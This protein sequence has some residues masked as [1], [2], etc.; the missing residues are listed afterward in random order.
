VEYLFHLFYFYS[1]FFD[2]VIL[3]PHKTFF[4]F[5]FP[6][7]LAMILFIA[8][9]IV[10]IFIQSLFIEHEK[11]LIQIE[12][13]DPFGCETE[14]GVDIE[15]YTALNEEKPLG[16]FNGFKTYTDRNHLAFNELSEGWKK[17]KT[18]A[19]FS[20]NFM[21]LPFYKALIFTLTYTFFVTP[22]V[23]LLGFII[24]LSINALKQKIRGPVIFATILPMIVTP[25]VG[26]LVLFWMIDSQ[27]II[28]ATIQQ[29]FDDPYLSLKASIKLTWITLI[30]Y[31]VWHHA[32][33]AFIVFYAALQTVPQDPLEAAI[34]DGATRWQRIRHVVIPHLFPVAVFIAL[35]S[36]MDNIR[37]FEPILGFSAEASAQS[38]SWLIYND[39]RNIE[40]M[41]FGSAASTSILTIIMVAIL[42]TPV[43]IKTWREFRETR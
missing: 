39:L 9:P 14:V 40:V 18:I 36:M 42:L 21:N 24:A 3:M 10:S 32:P 35:I 27:G 7:C 33:F 30:T 20:K 5:M 6:T 22:L 41:N 8:I 4:W 34:I 28:G 12:R 37:V 1:E 31:G 43:L 38:F 23:L 16:R 25:L 26:S 17:S 13:C 15:A 11:P 29:L 2:K 19:E